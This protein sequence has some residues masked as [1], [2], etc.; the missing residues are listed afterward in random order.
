MSNVID[1]AGPLGIPAAV[2]HPDD[3]MPK[4]WRIVET[5]HHDGQDGAYVSSTDAAWR[6]ENA[7]TWAQIVYS[8]EARRYG[9]SHIGAVIC[10]GAE[11]LTCPSVVE[12]RY[13]TV[14]EH[15]KETRRAYYAERGLNITR[16]DWIARKLYVANGEPGPEDPFDGETTPTWDALPAPKPE[17]DPHIAQCPNEPPMSMHPDSEWPAEWERVT[18]DGQVWAYEEPACW[19]P[20]EFT[21][22]KKVWTAHGARVAQGH[23]HRSLSNRIYAMQQGGG[24]T[25]STPKKAALRPATPPPPADS[26]AR[27]EWLGQQ[28]TMMASA[29]EN[30][31]APHT[32]RRIAAHRALAMV[33][34]YEPASPEN[35]GMTLYG[36]LSLHLAGLNEMARRAFDGENGDT[37]A[38]L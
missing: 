26:L 1:Q 16:M 12:H 32:R 22:T 36:T 33:N 18:I 28:I 14:A 27:A 8:T 31:Y 4:S 13:T 34:G 23:W 2:I 6:S 25:Q 29:E 15:Y 11:A 30:T 7:P 24:A 3:A 21:T 17:D 5:W 9:S 10:R 37:D 38:L 19:T 35:D 20:I